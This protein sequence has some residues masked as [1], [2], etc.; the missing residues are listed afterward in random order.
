VRKI[1][2]LLLLM[3]TSLSSFAQQVKFID[4]HV[5]AEGTSTAGITVLNLNTENEVRTTSDG[6][7]RIEVAVDHL[8]IFSGGQVDHYRRLVEQSDYERGS[9]IVALTGR[10]TELQE[11]II[12]NSRDAVSMGILS[13]PAKRFTPAERR[14]NAGTNLD[15]KASVGT[16]AGASMSLDP[17]LNWI[18]GRTKKLKKSLS[19]ERDEMTLQLLTDMYDDSYYIEDLK[20]D[21]EMIGGFRYYCIADPD[22]VEALKSGNKFLTAFLIG[23]LAGEFNALQ[24]DEN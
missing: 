10:I 24:L 11:V 13:T 14:L 3:L 18:S 17:L 5:T 16:M 23:K 12:D 8:L 1:K 2:L 21:R 7:F 20:I 4:G 9:I 22:F 19:I 6:S 15:A